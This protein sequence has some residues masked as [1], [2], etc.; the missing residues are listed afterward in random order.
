MSLQSTEPLA[1]TIHEIFPYYIRMNITWHKFLSKM[2]SICWKYGYICNEKY[3]SEFIEKERL[4]N[5]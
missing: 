5:C 2:N 4:I 1:N 3:K